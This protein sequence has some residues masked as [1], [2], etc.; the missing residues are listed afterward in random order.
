MSDIENPPLNK[1]SEIYE[2]PENSQ[3]DRNFENYERYDKT[4]IRELSEIY[5]D[6]EE[7]KIKEDKRRRFL[8][9]WGWLCS[10]C[11]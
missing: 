1:D 5:L 4:I 10:C 11:F 3:T 9:R 6:Q 8:K 7:R 2:L